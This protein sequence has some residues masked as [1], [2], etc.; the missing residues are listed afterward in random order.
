MQESPSPTSTSPVVLPSTVKFPVVITVPVTLGK[1]I[2]LSAVGSAAVKVV[3]YAFA[4]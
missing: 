3:S 4:K 1:V 2:V